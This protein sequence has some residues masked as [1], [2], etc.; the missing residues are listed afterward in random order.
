MNDD[1]RGPS[2]AR[3]RLVRALLEA[4]SSVRPPA[5]P[6]RSAADRLGDL[7]SLKRSASV[8]VGLAAIGGVVMVARTPVQQAFERW[9]TQ[10]EPPAAETRLAPNAPPPREPESA[11]AVLEQ[12]SPAP[13]V[14]PA[15]SETAP[16][17]VTNSVSPPAAAPALPAATT[18]AGT[19][20]AA[21]T[22]ASAVSPA[23][24][25]AAVPA[26]KPP[27]DVAVPTP[28]SPPPTTAP[29]AAGSVAPA[30]TKD[31]PRTPDRAA[32]VAPAP[33]A[34]APE[35]PGA[36]SLDTEKLAAVAEKRGVRQ[37]PPSEARNDSGPAT[38][39]KKASATGNLPAYPV[40]ERIPP[41][42]TPFPLTAGA[43][44]VLD[45]EIDEEGRVMAATVRE[46]AAGTLDSTL[47]AAARR[48]RYR[49]AT[50]GGVPVRST[51]TV[52]VPISP[53]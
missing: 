51:R 34:A 44:I 46:S 3:A 52:V 24:G 18:P 32:A 26:Q 29:N 36:A 37:P 39:A 21:T 35:S 42:A 20:P 53:Q 40:N 16:P 33:A 12:S 1:L 2:E 31:R 38:A 22:P 27:V 10:P 48:W 8:I 4:D 13:N 30:A 49:P 7:R 9:R 25:V 41:L 23:T 17:A 6:W 28:S 15:P 19:T 47:L 11:S 43:R 45:L 14:S 5:S 50:R